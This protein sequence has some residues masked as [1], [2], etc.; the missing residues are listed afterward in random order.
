MIVEMRW[1][2]HQTDTFQRMGLQISQIQTVEGRFQRGKFKLV[3]V[4][5]KDGSSRYV[6]DRI[7]V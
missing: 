7:G 1:V 4:Y 2:G 6:D 5:L 3:Q